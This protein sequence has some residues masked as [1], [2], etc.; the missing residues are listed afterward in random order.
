M[1]SWVLITLLEVWHSKYHR[2]PWDLGVLRFSNNEW[3]IKQLQQPTFCYTRL[4][5]TRLHCDSQLMVAISHNQGQG[6]L[7]LWTCLPEPAPCCLHSYA[8]YCLAILLS[9]PW[10]FSLPFPKGPSKPNWSCWLVGV[11]WSQVP[12]TDQFSTKRLFE[13]GTWHLPPSCIALWNR[14]F[15]LTARRGMDDQNL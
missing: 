1:S 3:Q 15:P 12:G 8:H 13:N 5:A 10:T 6:L 7:P 14:F 2:Q 9:D 4:R 11:P